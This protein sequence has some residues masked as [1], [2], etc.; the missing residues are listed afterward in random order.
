MCYMRRV[1]GIEA[2]RELNSERNSQDSR[3]LL[4]LANGKHLDWF[5]FIILVGSS[6]DLYVPAYS[7]LA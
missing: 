3:Y 1:A 2:I 4:E 5:K 6:D 7:S